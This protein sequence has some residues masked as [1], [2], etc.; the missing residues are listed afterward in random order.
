MNNLRYLAHYLACLT[1][2][3]TGVTFTNLLE[4][5]LH[6][7]IF[8]LVLPPHFLLTLIAYWRAQ[9]QDDVTTGIGLTLLLISTIL[10]GGFLYLTG[11]F[12][13]PLIS[14]LLLPV[15]VS[16]AILS[17][18]ATL[19]LT[20]L[21]MLLYAVLTQVYHPLQPLDNSNPAHMLQ[22]HFWGMWLTFTLSVLLLF[23]VVVPL[24]TTSRRQRE[25]IMA[26]RE[27]MLEDEQMLALA[28]FSASAT[29]Q[30]ATPLST[31][32]VLVDDLQHAAA[33][34]AS[35]QTNDLQRMAEQIDHCKHILG[36]MAQRA[37]SVRQG[38]RQQESPDQLVQRLREEYLLL[39]PSREL[40]LEQA[41]HLGELRL[42][43]DITL[44]QA[45][46]N[47]LDNATQVSREAVRLVITQAG[48]QLCMSIHDHGPGVPAAIRDQLGQPFVS[49]RK[50]GTGLGLFLSHATLNRFGGT[51]SLESDGAGTVTDIR[52]PLLP[53]K[54]STE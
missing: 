42:E 54:D 14:L 47:L 10:L 20:V 12:T 35:T 17:W 41:P 30:M 9:R 34:S 23:G 50:G 32:A 45:I 21:V 37:A 40:V 33:T 22:L 2:I 51:L 31:L 44:D 16:A 7:S 48:N 49:Q 26:Q 4:V 43:T 1:I 38:S 5:Q 13:N 19:S 25:H 15:A 53:P 52:L 11:G 8:W 36:T 29:H 6:W 27:K 28:T 46:L 18:R 3:M 24:A 39:H